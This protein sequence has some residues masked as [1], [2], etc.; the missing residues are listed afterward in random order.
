[1]S[2]SLCVRKMILKVCLYSKLEMV[3]CVGP[4]RVFLLSFHKEE[5]SSRLSSIVC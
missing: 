3:V 1:M 4:S 2:A 5:E